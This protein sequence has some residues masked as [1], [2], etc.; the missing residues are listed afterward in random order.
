MFQIR[1][2]AVA[3]ALAVLGIAGCGDEDFHGDP[4]FPMSS[5]CSAGRDPVGVPPHLPHPRWHWHTHVVAWERDGSTIFFSVGAPGASIYR[6]DADGSSLGRVARTG[7]VDDDLVG[8]AMS[9]SLSP[10]G[11]HLVYGSC[12]H[13]ISSSPTDAPSYLRFDSE[14][15]R[16][17]ADGTYGRRLTEN[18][19]VDGYPAWSPDGTR[20]AFLSDRRGSSGLYVHTMGA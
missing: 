1:K 6:I 13:E 5:P 7:P 11:W 19:V 15:E 12:N 20:I 4:Q 8:P 18:G 16:V 9:F 2:L 17:S 10:A 14:L 3:V